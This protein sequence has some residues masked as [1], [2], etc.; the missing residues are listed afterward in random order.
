V[1]WGRK[2]LGPEVLGKKVLGLVVSG[3]FG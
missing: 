1:L 2:S 3:H